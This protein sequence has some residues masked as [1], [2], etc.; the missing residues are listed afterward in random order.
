MGLEVIGN[1][2]VVSR[3]IHP[4]KPP[5]R[6]RAFRF[7]VGALPTGDHAWIVLNVRKLISNVVKKL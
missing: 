1:L 4:R 3:R 6:I 5:R 2:R 7:P